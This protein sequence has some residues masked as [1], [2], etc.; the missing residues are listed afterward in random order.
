MNLNDSS[1]NQL[2]TY[3][4]TFVCSEPASAAKILSVLPDSITGL[5][6]GSI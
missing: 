3:I 4:N 2:K 1:A 5:L 6:A